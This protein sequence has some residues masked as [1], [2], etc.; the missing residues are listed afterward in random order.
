MH[1]HIITESKKTTF[2]SQ[3]EVIYRVQKVLRVE[4]FVTGDRTV[5]YHA[6]VIYEHRED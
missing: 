2:E 4:L 3:L 1:V 5:K 6:I